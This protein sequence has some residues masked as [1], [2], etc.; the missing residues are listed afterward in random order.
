[1]LRIHFSSADLGRL[2]L[3]A[4]PDVMWETVLSLHQ[5]ASPD[6]FFAPWRRTACRALAD[7]G[8]GPDVRLLTAIAP[9]SS[10]FPDFLTPPGHTT[11]LEA[12]IDV[13]LSTARCRLRAEIDRLLE[14]RSCL[15]GRLD[16]IGAGRPPALHR[17]GAALR[18]YHA[19]ALAP[20]T[21][22]PLAWARRDMARRAAV[23][24]EQG[25]E[26]ML[27]G[28][29]PGLRWRPPVLEVSYPVAR[30]VR[31]AGRGLHLVPSF[32]CHNHPI[33][34]ADP[35]LPPVLIYPV[36]RTALWIPRTP[37]AE[38]SAGQGLEELIGPTRAAALRFLDT[39]H[40][41]TALAGRL[42]VSAS[43]ASR[44][45]AALR[46]AGLVA[47]ERLGASVLH[48]RTRLGTELVHGA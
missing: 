34:F 6:P 11:A 37:S 31:L 45:A 18:R 13:V 39:G 44:H 25:S 30:N 27:N 38:R 36:A 29:C 43:T 23:L 32:F 48:T 21:P 9:I 20:Y 14:A 42:C 16:G 12:G 10:Y 3:A 35:E 41:T 8:L 46:R 4:Q 28:L 5:L 17:L 33:G 26:A 47:T 40:S 7:A 15:S 24:L 1:M 19:V 2:R 22:G